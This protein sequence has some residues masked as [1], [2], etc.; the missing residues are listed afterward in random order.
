MKIICL[1]ASPAAQAGEEITAMAWEHSTTTAVAI[2]VLSLLVAIALRGEGNQGG[3]DDL[4]IL[5]KWIS[6]FICVMAFAW[7]LLTSLQ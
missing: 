1:L 7:I 3:F 2:F 6:G 4:R 5:A